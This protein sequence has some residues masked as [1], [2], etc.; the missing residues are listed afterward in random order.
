MGDKHLTP[1]AAAALAMSG[2]ADPP[3]LESCPECRADVASLRQVVAELRA[4]PDPPDALLETAK[5][6]FRKRRSID[7][8]IGRLIED[9][10]LREKARLT[11]E[12]VLR[13]AGLDPDADLV[14]ALR[15]LDRPSGDLARRIAAK[16][17]LQ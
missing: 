1:E 5:A 14:A 15:E 3:H 7:A 8:L 11:P 17:F 12:A 16:T 13:E 10:A 9:P 6:Y 4:L 2:A